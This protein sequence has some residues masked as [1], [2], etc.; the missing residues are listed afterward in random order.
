MTRWSPSRAGIF[1][2]WEYDDQVFEFGDGRLV[3]RGRNGSGKSNAL[4]LIFPFVLDG[5]MSATRMDPM[6]GA[7][8]M[9]SLLLGRDD[10]DANGGR[11]REDS[12]QGYVWME[13][14]RS[15]DTGEPEYLT[16]GVGARATQQRDANAWFFVTPLRV[17]DELRLAADDVPKGQRELAA[18]LEGRGDVYTTA[19]DYRLAVDRALFGLGAVRWRTLL[20]LLLTLRRPHLAGKL[21]TEHLSFTLSS[22]LAELDPTLIADVAHSFDDLDAMHDELDGV[23]GALAAV[24]RFLPAYRAHLLGVARQRAAHLVGV[25]GEQRKVTAEL[26]T[27]E[28]ERSDADAAAL[29]AAALVVENRR[30]RERVDTEIEAIQT[31]QAFQDAAALTEVEQRAAA[32]R[33]SADGALEARLAQEAQYERTVEFE[34]ATART[35]E[36]RRDELDRAFDEW[37]DLAITVRLRDVSTSIDDFTAER[38]LAAATVRLSEVVEVDDLAATA[39]GAAADARRAVERRRQLEEAHAEARRLQSDAEHSVERAGQELA[40]EIDAWIEQLDPIV[41]RARPVVGGPLPD[42]RTVRAGHHLTDPSAPAAFDSVVADLRTALAVTVQRFGA[43]ADARRTAMAECVAERQRVA[44]EPNPGPPPDPTRPDAAL[45]ARAGA[46]LYMCV[47]FAAAIADDDRA[48]LEAALAAAG[49]LDARIVPAGSA[50]EKD[51]LDA[52]I[53]PGGQPTGAGPTLADVLTPL[54]V[55]DLG[56]DDINAALRAVALDVGVVHIGRDGSWQLGPLA[57][58]FCKQRAEFIGHEARERRRAARL[59]ELDVEIADEGAALADLES[60]LAELSSI[61]DDLATVAAGRPSGAPLASARN[62][63]TQCEART[64]QLADQHTAAVIDADI[65]DEFASTSSADLYRRADALAVPVVDDERRVLHGAIERSRH[66]G[67]SVT[68]AMTRFAEAVGQVDAAAVAR[69]EA[70]DYLD[71]ATTRADDARAQ[72]D[73]D[74]LRY[75]TLFARVGDDVQAA[76]RALEDARRRRSAVRAASGDLGER[77]RLSDVAIATL[78]ERCSQL[79]QRVDTMVAEVAAARI[80]MEAVC[81]EEVAD[82]LALDGVGSG[83]DALHA[84]RTVLADPTEIPD[85]ATNRMEREHRTVLLDGLR[86]GHDPSM[87]KL[88]GFDVVRVGTADGEVP[89][90]ALARRLRDD[91]DRLGLLLS[92]REREIFETHLLARVGEALRELLFEADYFEQRIN[93][94]MAKAPTSS[95][96]TVE[97]SWG[98]DSDD[99]TVKQAVKTLRY[100]PDTMGPEQREVLRA[101]FTEQIQARR[102]AD[103][104]RSFVDVLTAALDYRSWHS[105]TFSI[106]SATGGRRQV[107]RKYFRELSGGEAATVLH[108]PLFAAAAAH[109]AS[110]SI[111]GPRLIALDEAFAGID[112][113]MRGKLMGLLVQLDLDVLLTSHE[114]WGFYAQVPNLVL[115]DLTRRPPIP[116]VFAQRLEWSSTESSTGSSAGSSTGSLT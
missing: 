37:R 112:D 55:G 62:V 43:S 116:G 79:R 40:A 32:A 102:A 11:Y 60:V 85:D 16:V 107:T 10:D 58:R 42:A 30:D 104:G 5:V 64:G 73:D 111:D 91:R 49:L 46:P 70:S 100:S 48:G 82:V 108:L 4:S 45:S 115:Y 66:L 54:A 59:D 34:A 76:V 29:R 92:D 90:G 28:R 96:M 109:Y 56:V 86:A 81:V 63:L 6:G 9:K 113:D 78:T 8:S 19:E 77:R 44:D 65:A 101:F 57:G 1:N 110:G 38:V 89:I 15:V 97:L 3:L 103:P 52:R 114:F 98:V 83:A 12:G 87:P 36:R 93:A 61:V 99:P 95:G 31:S 80:A 68:A 84:A 35:S 22:G 21:D 14:V 27:S 17:G 7:R 71:A 23:A 13:F 39:S 69:I 88:D 67:A 2:I 50:E 53:S 106:R 47:D 51:A 75:D 33:R 74:Q 41:A 25:D 26:R 105:F 20:D 72:A 18:S 24:E 94:E